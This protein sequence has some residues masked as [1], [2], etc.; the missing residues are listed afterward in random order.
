M[1][2]NLTTGARVWEHDF[3]AQFADTSFPQVL[4]EIIVAD[5]DFAMLVYP[6]KPDVSPSQNVIDNGQAFVDGQWQV[7]WAVVDKTEQ[8]L[9]QD[10]VMFRDRVVA[11][12]QSRLD[13]FARTRNYDSCLS[14]CSYATSAVAKFAAEGQYCATQRDAS[15][16]TLYEILAEVQ[17]GTRPLPASFEEIEPLLP[18]LVWPQ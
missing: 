7:Q 15:W 17:A 11:N 13:A 10:A 9:A 3:K 16:E 1:L 8:E 5:F 2:L 12:T 14:A 18:V 6:A 4:T